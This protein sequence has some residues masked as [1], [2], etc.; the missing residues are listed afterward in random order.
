MAKLEFTDSTFQAEVLNEKTM[1]VL[2]DF[3]AEWCGPC[4]VQRPIIEEIATEMAGQVKIG[5]LEVDMNPQTQG[6]YGIMSIPT[7]LIFKNGQPVEQMVGVQSKD[8]IV[9]ALKKAIG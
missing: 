2:V 7:L 8:K 9:A 5:E 4:K 3:W 6:Q 1:P